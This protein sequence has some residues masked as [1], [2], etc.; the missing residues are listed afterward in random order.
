[1]LC[2][3]YVYQYRGRCMGCCVW[4]MWCILLRVMLVHCVWCVVSRLSLARTVA[5]HVLRKLFIV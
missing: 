2:I 5:Y 3:M 1:M 4:S